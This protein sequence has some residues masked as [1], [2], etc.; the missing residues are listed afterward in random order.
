MRKAS[1]A[2]RSR[3]YNRHYSLVGFKFRRR[4]R[5]KPGL[6]LNRELPL[7]SQATLGHDIT[8]GSGTT[9]ISPR[10]VSRSLRPLKTYLGEARVYNAVLMGK[11]N[12]RSGPKLLRR[13][14]K[15]EG[16]NDDQRGAHDKCRAK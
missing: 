2:I 16:G 13:K 12:I 14:A 8:V 5:L 6:G 4:A 1:K 7:S 11:N 3:K 9:N 10:R 15:E